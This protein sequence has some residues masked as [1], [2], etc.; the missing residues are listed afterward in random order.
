[1]YIN[2]FK[3]QYKSNIYLFN[4]LHLHYDS[5]ILMVIRNRETNEDYLIYI[6]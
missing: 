5:L 3:D 2:D 6:I 1:M 4:L